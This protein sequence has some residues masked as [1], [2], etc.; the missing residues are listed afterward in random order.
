MSD[1]VRFPKHHLHR[2]DDE[3]CYPC[4]GGLALCTICGGAEASM[5]TDCPGRPMEPYEQDW[6]QDGS[7]DYRRKQPGGW[8]CL[9]VEVG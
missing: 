8:V 7:M 4:R 6:V 3:H 1:V 9:S 2:C 5:P